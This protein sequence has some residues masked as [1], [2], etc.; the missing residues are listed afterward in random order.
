MRAELRRRIFR[1]RYP[2]QMRFDPD[3][4]RRIRRSSPQHFARYMWA[5][6]LSAD[7]DTI[8]VG[9]GLGLSL[10]RAAE[11]PCQRACS[12]STYWTAASMLE[13]GRVGW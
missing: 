12:R 1:A 11:V 6:V 7:G 4:R 2:D 5:H 3:S 10:P 13:S 9:D 8:V